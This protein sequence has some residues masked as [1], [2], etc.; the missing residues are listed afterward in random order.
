MKATRVSAIIPVYNRASVLHD[1]VESLVATRYPNLEIVIVDDGSRDQSAVHARHLAEQHPS[2]VRVAEHPDGRN[3]GPGASRNLGVRLATGEYVCFLDS[4]DYVLSHRFD[5]AVR[6]LDADETIDAVCEPCA[7]ED[8]SGAVAARISRRSPVMTRMLGPGVRWN[9]N[10]I[11]MR[12]R[13]FLRVGG[14]SESLR[15]CE[16]LVL[17]MKLA[18]AGK[19]VEGSRREVAIY[20]VHGD[21]SGIILE[22]SLRAHLEVL[23]W[24]RGRTLDSEKMAAFRNAVWGKSLFVC[25]RLRAEGRSG[26]AF[27]ALLETARA[28]PAAMLK[29]AFWRNLIAAMLSS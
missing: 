3:H 2:L 12:K 18:L 11:V 4:D 8:E 20:R 23:R 9:T 28:H 21:N 5:V 27:E 16:D 19:M 7:V 10:S 1:A 29:P 22:N 14:F 6:L 15:T 25:D 17:W 24:S 26:A 13:S